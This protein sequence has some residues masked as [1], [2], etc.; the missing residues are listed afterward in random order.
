MDQSALILITG[1]LEGHTCTAHASRDEDKNEAVRDGVDR[2]GRSNSAE[3]KA[4]PE[5]FHDLDRLGYSLDM[6]LSMDDGQS[7]II[8]QKVTLVIKTVAVTRADDSS[9]RDVTANKAC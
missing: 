5:N 9:P 4:L 6:E 2:T 7:N 8:N 3:R 1:Y